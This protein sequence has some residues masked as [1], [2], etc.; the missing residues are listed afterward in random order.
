VH[1]KISS[2]T[3][4]WTLGDVHRFGWRHC[5]IA[6]AETSRSFEKFVIASQIRRMCRPKFRTKGCALVPHVSSN[7]FCCCCDSAL[8]Q[9]TCKRLGMVISR[10]CAQYGQSSMNDDPQAPL[11]K[12]LSVGVDRTRNF[13]ATVPTT[14]THHV[15]SFGRGPDPSVLLPARTRNH[16]GSNLSNQFYA[17]VSFGRHFK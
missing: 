17:I 12:F 2:G 11:G 6:C 10:T 7:A 4:R 14:G 16:S 1:W 13:A 5:K 15:G 8:Q 9:L 3:A